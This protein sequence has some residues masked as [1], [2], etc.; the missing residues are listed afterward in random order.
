LIIARAAHIFEFDLIDFF[1]SLSG[2]ISWS[3]I[4]SAASHSHFCRSGFILFT[5][6]YYRYHHD[7]WGRADTTEGRHYYYISIAHAT[8]ILDTHTLVKDAR[9]FRHLLCIISGH[10]L[11]TFITAN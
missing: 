5:R 7:I 1:L 9:W 6:S 11:T 10:L 8:L 4:I 2:I 3:S